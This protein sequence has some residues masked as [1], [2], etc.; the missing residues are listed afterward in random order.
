M[1]D[2]AQVSQDLGGYEEVSKRLTVG[3][4]P[5]VAVVDANVNYPFSLRDTLLRAAAAGLY[6]IGLSEEILDKG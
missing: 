1:D 2:L 5:F 4:A 3:L 6:Q